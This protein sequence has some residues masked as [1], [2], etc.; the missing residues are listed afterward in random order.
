MSFASATFNIS[1]NAG[2]NGSSVLPIGSIIN[3][4]GSTAPTSWLLCDGTAVSRNTYTSLFGVIGTTYGAGDGAVASITSGSWSSNIYT[5]VMPSNNTNIAVGTPFIINGTGNAGFDGITWTAIAPTNA[6]TIT[7]NSPSQTGAMSVGNVRK[8]SPTTFNIPNTAGRMVR[9]VGTASWTGLGG[10]TASTTIVALGGSGGAD[11]TKVSV[12]NLPQHRHGF[13]LAAGGG[14]GSADGSNGNRAA[15]T[16]NYT[17][18]GQTYEDG[19]LTLATNSNAP[20]L[21]AYV[22]INYII[23]FS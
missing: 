14:Y 2:D 16:Q 17:N 10:G 20:T 6:T 18:S 4:G 21:N 11:G 9:G 19:S 12:D 22:G 23:K 8:A 3:F 13:N 5:I 1:P 15:Q 7:F